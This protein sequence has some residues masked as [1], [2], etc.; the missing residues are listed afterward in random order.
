MLYKFFALKVHCIILPFTSLQ[1]CLNIFIPP[2][3]ALTTSLSA[4]RPPHVVHTFIHHSPT[5]RP[6]TLNEILLSLPLFATYQTIFSG[7]GQHVQYTPLL[8]H[9]HRFSCRKQHSYS[10]VA[11]VQI[12]ATG[13][14]QLPRL[15]WGVLTS[16]PTC[17][18][19]RS[20]HWARYSKG[21]KLTRLA[22]G[23]EYLT[24]RTRRCSELPTSQRIHLHAPLASVY[25]PTCA[26]YRGRWYPSLRSC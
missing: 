16:I 9:T 12:G 1:Y 14:C 4:L 25:Q 6:I 3:G 13:R 17:V 18:T 8:E 20:T 22:E 15:I 24:H 21:T 5:G 26:I 7:P 19:L 10:T 23:G 2:A 11:N